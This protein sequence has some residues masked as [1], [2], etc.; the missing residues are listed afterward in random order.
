MNASCAINQKIKHFTD[1]E[2]VK[3]CV[4]IVLELMFPDKRRQVKDILTF[5][6][7][8]ISDD[9]TQSIEKYWINTVH[10]FQ[11]YSFVLD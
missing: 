1:G 9:I 4:V 3:E 6:V 11:A 10:T 5:T 2:P 8:C 7:C